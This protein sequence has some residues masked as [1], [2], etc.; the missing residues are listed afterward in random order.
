MISVAAIHEMYC[1]V[2]NCCLYLRKTNAVLF[3][4]DSGAKSHLI[5]NAVRHC[6]LTIQETVLF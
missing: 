6:L 4:F 3:A 1:V 5:V 2:I